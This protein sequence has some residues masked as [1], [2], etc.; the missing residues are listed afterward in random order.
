MDGWQLENAMNNDIKLPITNHDYSLFGSENHL[1]GV[2]K[3]YSY[4]IH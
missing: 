1:T 4:R 3:R 2:M